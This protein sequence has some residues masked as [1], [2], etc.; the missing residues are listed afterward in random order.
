M[1]WKSYEDLDVYQKSYT[2][3]LEIHKVS[4]NFP[5]EEQY[6]LTS[7]LRRSSKSICANIVEG[8]A[9]SAKSAAEFF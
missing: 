7:Q 1:G 5:K 2:L 4:K 8:Q 9:K 3:A 6:S